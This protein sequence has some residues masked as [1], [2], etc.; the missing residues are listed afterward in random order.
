MKYKFL[1]IAFVEDFSFQL[2]IDS[3]HKGIAESGSM[4]EL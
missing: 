1:V 3:N 4:F 2:G